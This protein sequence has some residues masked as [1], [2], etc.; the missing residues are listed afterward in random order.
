MAAI[1]HCRFIPSFS[2]WKQIVILAID[3]KKFH[4]NHTNNENK[5]KNF[6][7]KNKKRNKELEMVHIKVAV[8]FIDKRSSNVAFVCKKHYVQVFSMNLVRIIIIT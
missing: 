3:E 5:L 8:A 4:I 2:E 7:N 1:S 6:K